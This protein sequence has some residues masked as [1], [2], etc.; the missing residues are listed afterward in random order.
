MSS[1]PT[2]GNATEINGVVLTEKAIKR[3]KQLQDR[4]NEG[5]NHISKSIE[6]SIRLIVHNLPNNNDAEINKIQHV[7]TD[8][9]HACDLIEDL[10]RP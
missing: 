8:L 7:L 9:T 2:P 10:E 4:D 6:R 1:P 5:I 3:L